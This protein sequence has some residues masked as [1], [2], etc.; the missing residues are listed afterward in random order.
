VDFITH[1]QSSALIVN[2]F[3]YQFFQ[4]KRMA[5]LIQSYNSDNEGFGC[6]LD[7]E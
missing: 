3:S 7:D 1:E 6:L 4:E 2:A 5:F